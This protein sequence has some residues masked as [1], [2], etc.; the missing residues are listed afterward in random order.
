M[1]EY[2]ISLRIYNINI[3]SYYDQ[4]FFFLVG[5]KKNRANISTINLA[6]K[7]EINST[8][9]WNYSRFFFNSGS[10]F[11]KKKGKN[12]CIKFVQ[13]LIKLHDARINPRKY[14]IQMTGHVN[15]HSAPRINHS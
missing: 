2:F 9:S 8:S 5:S 10:L 6:V 12:R 15:F 11:Y 7:R 3:S 1:R 14:F 13:Y 4:F